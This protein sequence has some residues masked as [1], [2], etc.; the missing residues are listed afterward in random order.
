ME[1][2]LRR[3]CRNGTKKKAAGGEDAVRLYEDLDNRTTLMEL[4]IK[5]KFDKAR[6]WC[7]HVK[8]PFPSLP[9]NSSKAGFKRAVTRY[10]IEEKSKLQEV[11]AGWYT[12]EAMASVLKMTPP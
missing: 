5:S 6:A 2:R 12:S 8:T 10:V 1:Q 4:F 11:K 7:K 3:R 9:N